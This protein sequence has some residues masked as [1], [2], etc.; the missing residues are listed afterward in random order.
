MLRNYSDEEYVIGQSTINPLRRIANLFM[1]GTDQGKSTSRI[2][3][4]PL[5]IPDAVTSGPFELDAHPNPLFELEANPLKTTPVPTE[6]D[7]QARK[8][9][10]TSLDGAGY[11]TMIGR[12]PDIIEKEGNSSEDSTDVDCS[13]RAATVARY[14]EN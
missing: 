11:K 10:L 2:S 9:I 8:V 3:N 5:A 14:P 12:K 6:E 1:N 13:V 4:E 7:Q